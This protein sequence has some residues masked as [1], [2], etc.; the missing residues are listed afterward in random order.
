MKANRQKILAVA[1]AASLLLALLPGGCKK[2]TPPAEAVPVEVSVLKIVPFESKDDS[3]DLHAKVEPNRVVH[4]A[5]EVAGRIEEVC[6][7]E[8]TRLKAGN[9][10]GPI[11]KLNTDLLQ[12]RVDRARS[13][14]DIDK[15]E[16]TRIAQLK[17][18]GVAT[19]SELDQIAAQAASSKATLREAEATLARTSIYPPI[20][21]VLN[22]RP[23]EQGDYVQAGQ[24]V[25][26]IVD[27]DTVKIVAHVPE[28]DIHFLK[29]GDPV[30]AIY[31]FKRERRTRDAKITFISK[32][33]HARALT[34]EIEVKVDNSAG[35]LFSGQ[36]VMLRL[37]RRVLNNVIMIPMDA[38]IPLAQSGG[39]SKYAAYVVEGAK[40]RRRDNIVID[41]GFIEEKNVRVVSGL[42]AG[43]RLIVAGQRYVGPGQRVKVVAPA[44]RPAATTLP[45]NTAS[46]GP[47]AAGKGT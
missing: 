35:E 38:V 7:A 25:A 14:A 6:C 23:V 42:A 37:R 22:H 28:R 36:I 2:Q 44:S 20:D 21:G 39:E 40:A 43:E 4:V 15:L 46:T 27:S 17:Q 5:A 1:V 19:I 13:Q 45:D 41:L 3:F 8:G 32:L 26:E 24:T 33:S 31:S 29:L 18:R 10:G 34:T 9:S 12:A 16:H 30:T 47:S 11:I